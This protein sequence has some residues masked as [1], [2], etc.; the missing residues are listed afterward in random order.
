MRTSTVRPMPRISGQCPVLWLMNWCHLGDLQRPHPAHGFSWENLLTRTTVSVTSRKTTLR[1]RE[2]KEDKS[3]QTAH[4]MFIYDCI[5]WSLYHETVDDPGRGVSQQ[6]RVWDVNDLQVEGWLIAM[7]SQLARLASKYRVNLED[8]C[9]VYVPPS[10]HLVHWNVILHTDRRTQTEIYW[11][12]LLSQ[13]NSISMWANSWIVWW[14]GNTR[15]DVYN[16]QIAPCM[17]HVCLLFNMLYCIISVYHRS[18]Q[19]I[20]AAKILSLSPT[21]TPFWRCF[22][23]CFFQRSLRISCGA[24][25]VTCIHLW[26]PK[27]PGDSDG[28][29][30]RSSNQPERLNK[31]VIWGSLGFV[32]LC[33]SGHIHREWNDVTW[34]IGVGSDDH[35]GLRW[36]EWCIQ[37]DRFCL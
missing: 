24:A 21:K 30:E 14:T 34:P 8:T 26:K 16:K 7:E 23:E 9:R 32:S 6:F 36:R 27:F 13:V 10:N 11:R 28:S 2:K 5:I 20:V 4:T 1:T 29:T 19:N 15:A 17:C 18:D 35:F 3:R 33:D 25:C 37:I 12:V 31:G 22:G